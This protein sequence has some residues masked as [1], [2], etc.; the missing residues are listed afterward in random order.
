[1][2]GTQPPKN[3]W[4]ARHVTAVLGPTN[5]GKTHLAIERMLG[6]ESGLIG[7]PL[8]LLAC[9]V[10]QRVAKR[11][12]E[13]QVALVT[14][15]EKIVPPQPRYWVS[16]V[17]AMPRDTDAAFVAIDEVQLAADLE[18]GHV[19][20]DRILNLRGSQETLLLGAATMRGIIETMLPGVQIITRPRMSVLAYAGQK[21]ITRLPE[22]SAVVTFSAADVYAIAELIRRQRGGAAVVLGALSP[23]TRNKQVEIFQSGDV[24]FI[25]ATDAIGMG[26]NLDI[27]HVAFASDRK[28][29]GYQHRPLT[30][31]ELGQVAGRAGRHMRD[32]TFGLT[33]RVDPFPAPLVEAIESHRFEPVRMLQWRNDELDF[34]SLDALRASLDVTPVHGGLTRAPPADDQVTLETMARDEDVTDLLSGPDDIRRLWDVCRLPDYRKIA[35]A[36][37]AQLVAEMVRYLIGEGAV[38][39]DWIAEQIRHAD[40]IDGDIDTLSTRIAHIR[41]WTFV[42]NQPDWLANPPYWRDE[43]RRV[44]DAISDALHD[45][46]TKRF[47]D[48][49]TSVLMRSLKENTMLEAEISASGDVMVEG[50]HV[51]RLLGFRFTPDA[52][53][54]GAGA[55]TVRAVAQKALAAA[56]GQRAEQLA[57]ADDKAIVLSCDGNLR[58]QGEPVARL[59]A[60]EDTLKPGLALLADEHLTGP[61]LNAV[62]G[63]L[64]QW[65]QTRIASVL[66]PLTGMAADESLSGLARGLAF[67]L[68]ENLGILDRR[69]VLDDVRALDQDARAGL[70]KHG[71]RFGAYHIYVPALLKPGAAA[72]LA[73]LWALKHAELD[74]P[75]LPELPAISASGR[76][77]LDVDPDFSA[78]VYR[79]F[80]YRVYG[81]RAV[82]IDILER[83]ADLIRPALSWSPAKGGA[84]PEGAINAGRGFI[85]T[86]AMNSLLGASGEDMAVILR[87]LGYLAESQPASAIKTETETDPESEPQADT[88]SAPDAPSPLA[89]T[90]DAGPDDAGADDAGNP[91]DPI[92]A[93]TAKTDQQVEAAEAPAQDGMA[94]A[95][96]TPDTPDAPVAVSDVETE[97]DG[98]N[99]DPAAELQSPEKPTPQAPSA[100]TPSSAVPDPMPD[101]VPDPAPDP[102]PADDGPAMVEVWRIGGQ[103]RQGG[104]P[105]R[106]S[107]RTDGRAD[108]SKSPPQHGKAKSAARPAANKAGKQ[109]KHKPALKPPRERPIDPDNPFA[110]LAALKKTLEKTDDR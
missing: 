1:M 4:S 104:R 72:F 52:E 45:Q 27:D 110:A 96:D 19:F 78:N 77:S 85:V 102:A 75:G 55:R 6:H 88:G 73:Q 84:A 9:E 68:V 100:E 36:Q 91:A 48:R 106:R 28:F 18:R 54:E 20:T 99:P 38:P 101:P 46:L 67:R 47:V 71:V 25:V 83:L 65:L 13:D 35:P 63:R 105:K 21:K 3:R 42:A 5:T 8:R 108:R 49:R 57:E 26:L 81:R 30:A 98:A 86:P 62:E 23:R 64:A 51:G 87:G 94:A 15:E 11:V 90:D 16:T 43:T 109:G 17:E 10:Y 82:R 80:G 89:K 61:A 34:S 31:A 37:H 40:R 59:V 39:D 53:A 74:L 76:T 56:I 2:N 41:T 33:A 7:L 44:E 60:G 12:G 22:R 70:R 79:R 24:D 92:E 107:Q 66:A 32:G 93:A 69:D 50:Q 14:G 95:P 58:W 29:D 103:R 97:Q